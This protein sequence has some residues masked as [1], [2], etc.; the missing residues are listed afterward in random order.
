MAEGRYLHFGFKFKGPPKI[1]ELEPLFNLASDW[2]RYAPNCWIVWTKNS[3]KHVVCE[4]EAP[5]GS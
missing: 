3:D 2:L 4:T 1:K 5:F